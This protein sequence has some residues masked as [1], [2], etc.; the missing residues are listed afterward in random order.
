M[1]YSAK[2]NGVN[3]AATNVT[4]I[5]GRQLSRRR[6]TPAANAFMAADIYRSKVR[7]TDLT[8]EQAAA[9]AGTNIAYAKRALAASPAQRAD[10]LTGK[11]KLHKL[12]ANGG[13][14]LVEHLARSTP[15]EWR[16][17]ARAVGV[18]VVWDR[19]IDPLI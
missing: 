12:K 13:E 19:M 2:T 14:S 6:S 11:A 7:V 16:A 1:F 10:V 3:G 9:L 18:D 5:T 4:T 17:A 15:D 8:L